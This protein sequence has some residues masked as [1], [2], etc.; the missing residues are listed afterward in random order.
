MSSPRL[1]PSHLRHDPRHMTT[2]TLC[3]C[4]ALL[5]T[6]A[7]PSDGPVDIVIRGT[8]IAAVRPSGEAEP[9]GEAIDAVGRLVTPGLVNGHHHS[10][11]LFHKGR[12]DNLPLELWMNFVR[13]PNPLPLTARQVY[14]RTILGAIEALRTGTT[15][16]I[17][18][19][20]V[21]PVLQHDH[22]EAV[23]RAYEDTGIRA[24]VG[25]SLF[26]RPFFRG[27]PFVDEEFPEELLRE[28]D[29]KSGTPPQEILEFA[30]DLARNRHPRDHRVGFMVAP[31][32][33]Q[34]CSEDF[35]RQVRQLADDFDLPVN[36]HVHETRLQA[37]TAQ[38][39]YNGTMIEYL[40]RTDFLRPKTSL[41]HAVWLTP[42]DIEILVETGTTVQHNPTSNLKLG[43]G[44]APVR[45]LL[46]AGVNISLGS[47]G[48]GSTETL[49]MLKVVADAALVHKLRGDDY[50]RWPGAA[51]AWLAGTRGGARAIG[52][53]HDLGAI[54]AGFT[55]DLTVYRLDRVPFLP[56]NNPLHQL[57]FGEMGMSLDMVFVAG[58][59]VMADG[60][61][62]RVDEDALAK[63]IIAEH[64]G[65]KPLIDRSERDV[66]RIR[67]AYERIYRRCLSLPIPDDTFDA[68]FRN[69]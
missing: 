36:I 64:A 52:R 53:E 33:P 25:L 9:E 15:T 61:L 39:F 56:L 40:R 21:S 6:D 32:A 34:R 48:C 44:L 58:E 35:L 8:T 4:L 45:A 30:R 57:V 59:Q 7:S 68:R 60:R 47:D 55:A 2:K 27:V 17:D 42:G 65:L 69:E 49:N 41:I 23:F 19:L 26:D 63:E 10:H 18:D 50:T 43:S 13:P 16:L 37:V 29:S 51:D 12:Y 66:E 20:N 5:G 3:N 67:A 28:L 54:A 1:G 46:D 22:V 14:L 38:L 62:A 31:S 11:E 24:L